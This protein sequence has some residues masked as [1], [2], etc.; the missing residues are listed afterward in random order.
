MTMAVLDLHPRWIGAQLGERKN[1]FMMAIRF[2]KELSH[3]LS[4]SEKL[5]HC[6]RYSCE[7]Q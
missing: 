7:P 2:L 5:Q 4:D 3:G 6:P 1:R